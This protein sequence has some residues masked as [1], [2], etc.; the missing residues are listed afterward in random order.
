MNVVK[1][2]TVITHFNLLLMTQIS[3]SVVFAIQTSGF[4]LNLSLTVMAFPPP[5][6]TL[7][8]TLVIPFSI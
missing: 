1:M 5:T 4:H 7:M 6:L 8:Q 3:V 2:I